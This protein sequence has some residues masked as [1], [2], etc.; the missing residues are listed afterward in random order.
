VV[1]LVAA[2]L[3]Q[4]AVSYSMPR[5]LG[6]L[7]YFQWYYWCVL[8]TMVFTAAGICLLHLNG[9]CKRLFHSFSV[10]GR[11]TL[12]NYMMQNVISFFIF[13]GVGLRLFDSLPYYV[14]FIIAI[15]LYMLQLVFSTWWL[16]RYAYGPLEG[17]WRKLSRTKRNVEV[18]LVNS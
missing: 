9:K 4:V 14:Y 1:S 6:Y 13:K 11:M 5:Q 18:E 10:V 12:T 17:L 16:K 7:K 8:A 2:V 15:G 3:M